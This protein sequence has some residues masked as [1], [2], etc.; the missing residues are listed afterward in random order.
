VLALRGACLWGNRR[1]L[2]AQ[3]ANAIFS[4]RRGTVAEE[5][6]AYTLDLHGAT[7]ASSRPS[8]PDGVLQC[9]RKKNALLYT[10]EPAATLMSV[11][12]PALPRSDLRCLCLLP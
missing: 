10:L 9:R 6:R 11:P 4:M 1:D 5:C 7:L 12:T 2:H 3:A 8:P